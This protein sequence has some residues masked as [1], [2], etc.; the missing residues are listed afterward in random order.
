MIQW[1]QPAALYF[2]FNSWGNGCAHARVYRKYREIWSSIAY[3]ILEFNEEWVRGEEVM[4]KYI[5]WIQ[6]R[7]KEKS[8]GHAERKKKC[9]DERMK[10]EERQKKSSTWYLEAPMRVIGNIMRRILNM[11]GW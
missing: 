11:A 7:K 8:Q 10:N 1:C 9:K 5:R 3:Y 2:S 4:L 6:K